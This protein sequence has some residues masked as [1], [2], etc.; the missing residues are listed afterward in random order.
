MAVGFAAA[1]ANAMLDGRVS[2]G[3]F[4]FIQFH[5]A[6]PGS[7]GTTAIAGNATRKAV[8]WAAASGGSI[9]TNAVIEWTDGE[10]D[11]AEDYTHFTLWTLVTGGV[12]GGS[13]TITANAVSD[14]GEAFRIASGGLTYSLNVAA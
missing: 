11:T 2:A 14:T 7:A 9:A 5:T 6:D 13:G 4:A 12:F 10:V 1:V 3:D 8:S